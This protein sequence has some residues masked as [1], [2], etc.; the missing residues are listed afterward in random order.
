MIN[1]PSGNI[2]NKLHMLLDSQTF[3]GSVANVSVV[4]VAR[5][6]ITSGGGVSVMVRSWS[7]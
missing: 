3:L 5:A 6:L 1:W 4:G 2:Q 7:V